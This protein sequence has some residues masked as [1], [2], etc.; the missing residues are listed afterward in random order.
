MFYR[1]KVLLA[2]VE[3][4]NRQVPNTDLQKYLFLV[5]RQQESP[6]YDF[7]PYRFGCYSFHADADK[8]A[9][10]KHGLIRDH[11]RWVLDSSKQYKEVLR[12]SDQRAVSEVVD[13]FKQVR[14]RN[15]VRYVYRTYPYYAINSE[16]LNGVLLPAERARVEASRPKKGPPRLF[17]IGYEGKSVEQ[18]LN[19]LIGQSVAVLCDVRQNPMS[20]KYGFSKRTL[21]QA[22]GGIGIDY[23]HKPELGIDSSKRRRLRAPADYQALFR[24]YRNTTLAEGQESLDAIARLVVDRGR[25]ALT[26]FEAASEQCHRGCVADALLARPDFRYRVTHL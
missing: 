11:D 12:Q 15:L 8:R 24:E 9:L 7:V 4:L 20:R 10:T 23:V 13:R 6:S 1:Q 2:L 17:T 22:C 16:I 3:E 18:F 21:Q 26:C 5:C 19:A 25:V 14:G